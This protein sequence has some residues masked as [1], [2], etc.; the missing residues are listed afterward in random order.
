M[1]ETWP[2]SDELQA[3]QD[4]FDMNGTYPY[5]YRIVLIE[6]LED[7]IYQEVLRT[8]RIESPI[9]VTNPIVPE[10]TSEHAGRKFRRAVNGE[11]AEV[12]IMN[13]TTENPIPLVLLDG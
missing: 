12:Q 2:T 6:Q 8:Y 7:D 4:P 3:Q 13:E 10:H 11:P 5:D 1:S 9:D